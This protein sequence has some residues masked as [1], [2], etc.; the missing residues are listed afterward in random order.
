MRRK[1]FFC[2][3]TVGLFVAGFGVATFPAIADLR[4]ITITLKGGQ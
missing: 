2:L 4:V 1:L 3:M